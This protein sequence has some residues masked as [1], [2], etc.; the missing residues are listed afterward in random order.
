MEQQQMAATQMSQQMM[1]AEQSGGEPQE[2]AMAM[3][4]DEVQKSAGGGET[5]DPASQEGGPAGHATSDPMGG[6][7][8]LGAPT[9]LEVQLE[10]EVLDKDEPLPEEEP[11]PED[12]F[13]EASRQQTSTVEYQNVR[14]PSRYAE[15]SAL[16][17]EHIP[18]RYRNLVRRYFLA[19]RPRES[20]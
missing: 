15:G 9:T 13:Q 2:G 1:A 8:P 19:I 17:V 14:G 16:A 12:L 11:D 20:K 4:S 10:M 6:E 18:W 7:M 5:G 3:P